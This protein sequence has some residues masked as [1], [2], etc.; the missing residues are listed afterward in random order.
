MKGKQS[1]VGAAQGDSEGDAVSFSY[2]PPPSKSVPSFIAQTSSL[3]MQC[4]SSRLT[5]SF[6][7]SMIYVT[8]H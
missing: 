5:W 1:L 6:P 3:I 2:S 4:D 7:V 8:S